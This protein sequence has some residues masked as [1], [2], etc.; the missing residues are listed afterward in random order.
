M[1][2]I[3]ALSQ[4]DCDAINDSGKDQKRSDG[5]GLFLLVKAAGYKWWRFRYRFD[6]KEKLLSLGVYPEITLRE[7][8]RKRLVHRRMVANGIDPAIIKKSIRLKRR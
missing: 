4:E 8:R 1:K 7:A 5:K 2:K 6:G 3:D